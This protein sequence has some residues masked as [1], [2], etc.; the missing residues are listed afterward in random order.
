MS[1]NL[2][3]IFL[4]SDWCGFY[5]PWAGGP[6]LH[7]KAGWAIHEEQSSKQ[8]SS[9]ASASVSASTFLTGVPSL[10]S[11]NGGL[12][13]ETISLNKCFLPQVAFSHVFHTAIETLTNTEIVLAVGILLWQTWPCIVGESWKDFG[14]L[15]KKNH[16][17]F[18]VW[19]DVTRPWRI[20]LRAF[21]MLQ[22]WLVKFKRKAD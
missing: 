22:D 11:F 14:T 5:L 7:K 20:M 8:C 10:T 15:Y 9:M 21:Q 12:R 2:L 16:W 1:T 4:I 6:E 13:W 3:S 17:V 19:W 18:Q